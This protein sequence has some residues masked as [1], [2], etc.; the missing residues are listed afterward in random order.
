MTFPFVC[1]RDLPHAPAGQH[2]MTIHAFTSPTLPLGVGPDAG[3]A[4]N[5]VWPAVPAFVC[6]RIGYRVLS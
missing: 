3:T 4:R 6:A 5:L 2:P 1:W